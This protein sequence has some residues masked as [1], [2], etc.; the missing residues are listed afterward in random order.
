MSRI[1]RSR[2]QYEPQSY[3]I[4]TIDRARQDC[5][6]RPFDVEAHRAIHSRLQGG[7]G[8]SATQQQSNGRDTPADVPFP[9]RRLPELVRRD[10]ARSGRGGSTVAIREEDAA[11][12]G[13]A[14]AQRVGGGCSSAQRRELH[15]ARSR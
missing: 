12:R 5:T 8:L 3:Y 11:G 6:I 7:L 4:V 14:V 10:S 15:S 13:G 1:P 9:L 2:S